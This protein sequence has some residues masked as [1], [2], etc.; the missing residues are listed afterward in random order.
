MANAGAS[1]KE[2]ASEVRLGL[3]LYGGVSLAIYMN[4]AVN[5]LFRAVR[6]RGPFFLI[7]E[8]LD[9][10]ITVDI[11][12]GTSAGGINGIFLGF[13]LANE[14]E[15]GTCAALW[16]EN[17]ALST[18][19]RKTDELE[20]DVRSVLDSAHYQ[21]LLTRGF[22]TMWNTPIAMGREAPSVV[23]E[24][25]LFITGTN[26]YGSITRKTDSFGHELDVKS[27]QTLFWLKHREQR[28]E[29]L[30]PICDARGMALGVSHID[31]N[32]GLLAFGKLA[33]ITSCFPGAFASVCVG[34]AR[35]ADE[36]A[37][38]AKLQ[39][40]GNLQPGTH[41]FVDGGVLDNK[42]FTSTLN[43][44][45]YRTSLRPVCRHLIYLEPDPERF[46]RTSNPP[47]P[48]APSFVRTVL[49]SLSGIPSYE[50]IAGDLEAIR[51]RNE[52]I[53]RFAQLE[54][55]SKAS[56][57]EAAAPE[58][59]IHAD[60]FYLRTRYLGLAQRVLDQLSGDPMARS[61][62]RE[63]QTAFDL[64]PPSDPKLLF[65]I[66]VE[67]PL[68]RLMD[69]TDELHAREAGSQSISP[70][71]PE[72]ATE[73]HRV[74]KYANAQIEILEVIRSALFR[75]LTPTGELRG[76]SYWRWALCKAQLVLNNEGLLDAG[77]SLS[78]RHELG[79]HDL[80][81]LKKELQ[82][83]SE[84]YKNGL[85][86]DTVR[87]SAE[88]ILTVLGAAHEK[89]ISGCTDPL[90]QQV[91]FNFESKDRLRYPLQL[92]SGIHELDRIRVSRFSPMDA[93]RG[94]CN[95]PIEEKL[96]GDTLG[97]FGA[98]LKRSWRSNDI[99]WGRLDGVCQ[100][101]ETLLIN[102]HFVAHEAKQDD[103]AEVRKRPLHPLRL[104]KLREALGPQR[105]QIETNLASLFPS[106]SQKKDASIQLA[107]LA[108]W[109]HRGLPE[110]NTHETR[111]EFLNLLTEV[112]Q[113]DILCEE[114]PRVVADAAQD[115]LEWNQYPRTEAGD[116]LTTEFIPGKT[117]L[118][119]AL[120][121]A[122]VHQLAQNFSNSK[123]ATA[124][125]D[126]F[127][128]D[129]KVGGET[130]KDIPQTVLAALGAQ[131]AVV[132]ERALTSGS[133]RVAKSIT[134]STLYGLIIRTPFRIISSLASAVNRSPSSRK[135]V[136]MASIGYIALAISMN[137]LYSNE[138]Y[139]SAG[140]RRGFALAAFVGI[141]LFLLALVG[142][143]VRNWTGRILTLIF[144]LI[145]AST[146]LITSQASQP[147]SPAVAPK[148]SR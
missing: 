9:A 142:A 39:M 8:L 56:N 41:Y 20:D 76:L 5:E 85:P 91:F 82:H 3:V 106:L 54:R 18:L 90:A 89:F 108:D 48:K 36:A 134:N 93:Q 44:I 83:R 141:P 78:T 10:E 95:R 75:A 116:S 27:H 66:D 34:D 103:I 6:G 144:L 62:Q 35:G 135:P 115:Q 88:S 77:A 40:W 137:V 24:L 99:L 51:A 68:R 96:S 117:Q 147:L 59:S 132:S 43:A 13:A 92:A 65:A 145:A 33:Q 79:P 124:L 121:A 15:F 60:R 101:L 119:P 72:G 107:P 67:Y 133:N 45:Y 136:L 114:L 61:A 113:L 47:A 139:A 94:Y 2:R 87:T 28:K 86:N 105:S 52:T 22:R 16:R 57:E 122:S 7:K 38:D 74:W 109:I 14:R 81:Q 63:L 111:N 97:H 21:K 31:E 104:S 127:R 1:A 143:W 55:I 53:D 148:P 131:A 146:L 4:G 71:S 46:P 69:L 98:F 42:P 140:F 120:I 49:D 126:Y 129:Y 64:D 128:N 80:D 17:G 110:L 112:A 25:D 100:L 125:G 12:S 29:Q 37:A 32:A 73:R 102:T 130:L 11:V 118:D 123:S 58:N 19:L 23:K 50:S 70:A 138:L 84:I 30:S 26:F